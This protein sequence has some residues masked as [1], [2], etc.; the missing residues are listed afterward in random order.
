MSN[1]KGFITKHS[2][3][4]LFVFLV[5]IPGLFACPPQGS[6]KLFILAGQSNMEGAGK[7]EGDPRHNGG[8]GSLGHLVENSQKDKHLK[9]KDGK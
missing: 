5:G 3:G 4:I 8:K 6:V 9:G 2:L 7:I 1:C